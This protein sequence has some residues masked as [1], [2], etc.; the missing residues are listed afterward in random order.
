MNTSGIGLSFA[1]A[2]NYIGTELIE[3]M[4]TISL[5][6]KGLV[7]IEKWHRTISLYRR[8]PAELI[9]ILGWRRPIA[10]RC[11]FTCIA[12]TARQVVVSSHYHA[13]AALGGVAANVARGRLQ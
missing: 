2:L 4:D 6:Q 7:G 13:H 9:R 11:R 12:A 3:G 5:I 10:P 8:F 1:L